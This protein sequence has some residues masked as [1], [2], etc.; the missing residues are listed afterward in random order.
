MNSRIALIASG[1]VMA[2]G[3][4]ETLPA[5]FPGIGNGASEPTAPT[6]SAPT[7]SNPN[8]DSQT[9]LAGAAMCISSAYYL[10]DLGAVP[11][12]QAVAYAERW[13]SI[14]EVIPAPTPGARQ[15]AV[16]DSYT[17]LSQLDADGSN[18]GFEVARAQFENDTCTNTEFQRDY[19]ARWGDAELMGQRLNEGTE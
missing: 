11:E 8:A 1:A 19:L 18:S 15:K 5:N 10:A 17:L 3:A 12:E 6:Q 4:C 16:D 14:I 7:T 2:L 9:G 13:T